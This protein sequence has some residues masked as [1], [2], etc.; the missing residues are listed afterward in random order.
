MNQNHFS[1]REFLKTGGS[2]LVGAL[3]LQSV[4]TK[5]FAAETATPFGNV[6]FAV[7]SDMHLD[8]KGKN[9]M[10]MSAASTTCLEKTV[11]ELNRETDLRFVL[12][13]GDLLLD[14]EVENLK[15]VKGLLDTLTMPYYVVCGNHDFI[16]PNPEKHRKDFHYLTVEEF[17]Q[18]FQ[19]HGYENSK[20]PYYAHE[21][22]PGLRVIG[23]DACLPHD[24][25]KWGGILP[26]EQLAWLDRQLTDHADQL[27]LIFMHH[28][29]IRWS[30]DEMKGGPKQWFCIDND[31]EARKL[32]TKHAKAAPVVIS[33]H[34]H[35]GLDH[36]EING[37]NYFIVPSLNS[38]P[39]RYSLFTISHQSL[40]WK[41]EMV[42]VPET[43]HLEARE[44]LLNAGWWRPTQFK[45]RVFN[46][47]TAVL[48]FYQNDAMRLGKIEL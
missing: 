4:G 47:D 35:I 39:M 10:K 41:T 48:D 29:F 15:I 18:S 21:I 25:K 13:A 22:V 24:P 20:R 42:S 14:G 9:G 28:N 27:N 5:V 38:Y 44:N 31:E 16:P 40:A 17:Y 1:R 26:K 8:I 12:V 23:L 36:K 32:L 34:R 30:A 7:I 6:R 33:G 2:S 19:G 43:V 45:E 46:N 37:V 3:L 11:A